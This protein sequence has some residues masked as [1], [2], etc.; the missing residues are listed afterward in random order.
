MIDRLCQ[1]NDEVNAAPA[2]R[3]SQARIDALRT[4]YQS[5]L[6]I[7]ES[8]NALLPSSGP[9][10]NPAKQCHDFAGSIAQP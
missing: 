7:G 4:G 3:L 9:W 10:T 2:R 6:R 8:L 5:L 1:A